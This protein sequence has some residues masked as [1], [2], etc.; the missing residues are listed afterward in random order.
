MGCDNILYISFFHLKPSAKPN[1][2]QNYG[3]KSTGP[4]PSVLELKDFESQF[5]NLV[6]N[7]QFGRNSNH[8]QK[9]LKQ[10]EI[11]IK[12]ENRAFIKADK[13]TNYYKMEGREY[14]EL[15]EREIQK[16]YQKVNP[17]EIKKIENS[18]K[19]IVTNLELEDRVFAT[20]QRQ[21]FASLKDHK[22]NFFNN[23][24]VRLINPTKSEV[25]K[26]S[27]LILDEII[28]TVRRIS[29]LS[30]WK[31]TDNVIQWFKS[32]EKKKSKKF[33]QL[34]V[35]NFYPSITEE[36]LKSAIEW[37]RQ[38]V[39]ISAEEEEIIIQSKNSILINEG[40]PWAKKG[41]SNFDVGQGSF[42]GAECAELV[43]L[44]ILAELDKIDRLS[45]GIYRDDC[46][47]VTN[48][49]PRQTEIIKKKMCQIF[50]K[51]VHP[52]RT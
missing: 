17:T 25:G 33:I 28:S 45:P 6:K 32:I 44:Y 12:S 35:M 19:S 48:A 4:A 42:D 37:A 11:R 30:Q 36:L 34:D 18:Q 14:K 13:S 40:T 31:S 23:P 39:K 38:F 26:I 29:G 46:L 8:F 7:I 52:C 50:S 1:A 41:T 2:K 43:G 5:A 24:K 3:F 16:E 10:D 9:I 51:H 49:S 21:C 20:T 27:K 47:A 22:D 15:V